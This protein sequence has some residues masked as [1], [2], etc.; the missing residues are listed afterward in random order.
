[1][2]KNKLLSLLV[3]LILSACSTPTPGPDKT[4]GGAILGAAWGAGAGAVIGN[5]IEPS[6]RPGEGAVVGAGFGLVSGALQGAGYDVL[7]GDQIRA[8]Q[9]LEALRIQNI[10]N[11]RQLAMIQAKLDYQDPSDVVS[12]VYQVF[13]DVDATNLRTGA[14]ENLETIAKGI[15]ESPRVAK[16]NIV[17][18]TDESGDEKYNKEL[19]KTRAKNVANFLTSYGVS[20]DR[21][22]VLS[23]GSKNPIATNSTVA[24]RQLNRRV[25]IYIEVN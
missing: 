5:Q 8:K 10:A 18:H 15:L 16:V 22:R 3:V 11:T 4:I 20:K 2:N 19:A 1:M 12:S 6:P 21:I 14:I 13:F 25:D 24:G 17:G 23:Q 7:E 9:D